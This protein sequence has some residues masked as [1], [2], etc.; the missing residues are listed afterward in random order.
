MASDT[1]YELQCDC[2]ALTMAVHGEPAASEYC[3]CA[4]CRA[5]HAVDMTSVTAW[6]ENQVELP[7]ADAAA[8]FDYTHPTKQMRRFGCRK[9]GTLLYARHRPGIPVIEHARFRAANNGVLP[10]ALAPA[11]HVFYSERVLDIDDALP[12]FEADAQSKIIAS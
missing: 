7:E 12:K 3:H 6:P 2:G 8:L 4:T 5:F 10:A 1:I 9:C 11:R